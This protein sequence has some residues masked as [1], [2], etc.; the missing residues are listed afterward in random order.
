VGGRAGLVNAD[1]VFTQRQVT[2]EDVRPLNRFGL[3]FIWGDGHDDG[4]YSYAFLRDLCPD[5]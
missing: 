4:L 1:T 5:D 2:L 3:Q